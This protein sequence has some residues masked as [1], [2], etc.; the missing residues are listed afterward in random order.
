[1]RSSSFSL[2]LIFLFLGCSTSSQPMTEQKGFGLKQTPLCI[3]SAKRVVIDFMKPNSI[4]LSDRIFRHGSLVI[5]TQQ[6]PESPLKQRQINREF[7][8]IQEQNSC[9]IVEK[10][11]S[12]IV[13]RKPIPCECF[14]IND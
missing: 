5:S 11:L 10:H 3:K 8:L 4:L 7:V 12:G 14:R 6:N 2:I 1:M 13:N 9:Y